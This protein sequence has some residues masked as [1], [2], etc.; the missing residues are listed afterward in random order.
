MSESDGQLVGE[1][2][3][4]LGTPAGQEDPYPIYAR[5]R[6][7]GP[8]ATGPDGTLYVTGYRACTTLLRDPRLRDELA[9]SPA[10]PRS[11]TTRPARPRSAA[12]ASAAKIPTRRCAR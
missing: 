4:A 12:A 5:L 9:K 1:L 6:A 2:V 7:L 11:S 8:A 10:S 3:A